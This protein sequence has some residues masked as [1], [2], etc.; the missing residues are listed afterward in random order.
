MIR[1]AVQDRDQSGPAVD[2][3]L[4]EGPA[5]H[6]VGEIDQGTGD[7]VAPVDRPIG[8][9]R[10]VAY[11]PYN[12][13]INSVFGEMQV[14]VVGADN[15]MGFIHELTL[16]GSVRYDHFSDVGSTTNPKI[17]VTLKPVSWLGLRGNYSTSFNAP[18]PVDQLGSLRNTAQLFPINAF[19][20]PGDQP[21]VTGTVALQGSNPGLTPQTAKSFSFG[22]DIEPPVLPGLRISAN[23]YNVKFSNI[24]RQPSPNSTIFVNFPDNVL[25]NVN[26]ITITQLQDFL[27]SSGAPNAA[28]TLAS[29]LGR[30]NT[31]TGVCNIYELVD[32]RQGNYGTVKI[33]GLD[34]VANYRTATSFG[35]LDFAVSGNYTLDRKSLTRIG[36][37]VINDLKAV[38]VLL[39]N[40]QRLVSDAVSRLQLQAMLGADIGN[41]RAQA[42]LNHNGGFDLVRCDAT[43]TPACLAS[44]TGVAT[45]NGQPQDRVKAFNTVNLF[46]KYTVPG[47]SL[48]LRDLELTLNINNVFD[49]D[50]PILKRITGSNSTPGYGNGFTLGRLVQF[51]LTKKF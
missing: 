13:S 24:I 32:F 12:R 29:A 34:F 44:T 9:I 21:T 23:Y 20:R 40:G 36:A 15:R 3:A 50:P 28:A 45:A 49:Q 37:P 10:S 43:T 16:S 51:G 48:L 18:S 27:N 2:G 14:P 5:R 33:Q 30:C 47:D 39:P 8:A 7:R 42:T 1:R 41:F 26:G 25:A 22:T 11:T 38:N 4:D 6:L 31:T 17:G 46:F 19:V 35:G